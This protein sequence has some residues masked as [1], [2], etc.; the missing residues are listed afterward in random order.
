MDFQQITL[1][2]PTA[3]MYDTHMTSE[4]TLDYAHLTV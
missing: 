4:E 2:I 1:A 3:V